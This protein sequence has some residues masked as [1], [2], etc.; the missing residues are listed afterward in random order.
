MIFIRSSARDDNKIGAL[1]A[2]LIGI[3]GMVGGGIFAVLGTAVSLAGGGT[4][5][6]FAIAGLVALLTCYAYVKL[7][8]AFP[9]AGG[10]AVFLDQAFGSNTFTG[11]LNLTLW[12]SYL[13]T[14]ALYACAFASYGAAFFSNSPDWLRHLLICVAI[15]LPTAINLLN[16]SM[17][18]K[19][20]SY[21]VIGKLM[22]L[23]VVVCGGMF[24]LDLNRLQPT[25][26]SGTGMLIVGGMVIFVAYEGFELIAN[27]A[28]DVRDPGKN[29][30]RAFYGSVV[31][32]IA[33][34]ILVAIVTVGG[35]DPA[36]IAQQQDY[37]LAAAARPALGHIGFILVAVSALLATF[38]A[39]N[40]TIYGNARLGYSLAV[41][42]ELPE[43]FENKAWNSPVAGVLITAGLSL[44][45]ANTVDMHAIAI[46]GSAGF[47]LIFAMVCAAAYK[48]AHK[49]GAHKLI[50]GTGMIACLG[51]MTALL[52]H[53]VASDPRAL[54]IFIAMLVVSYLFEWLYPRFSGRQ[55]R[56][57]SRKSA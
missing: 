10:T 15:L 25:E 4:P 14:I 20:E 13:V 33:L 9:E 36:I 28:G 6:A 19:S 11:G 57:S 30:P 56:N 5:I 7:S 49:I 52:A 41:D 24:H 3:G 32:V 40:A 44:L 45:L 38:S 47:L 17:V 2:A 53:T 46:L 42:G 48:L 21:I 37:A 50:C 8:C 34:Y 54:L 12:L 35:V 29:L 39:I 43:E 27:T 16:A 26:W 1:A 18:S 51:A 23:A 55:Q 31:F 22:L